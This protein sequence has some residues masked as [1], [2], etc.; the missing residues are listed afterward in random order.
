MFIKSLSSHV[1]L[2]ICHGSESEKNS[3]SF[4]QW[5]EK[6][7]EHFGINWFS[8]LIGN[9]IYIFPIKYKQTHSLSLKYVNNMKLLKGSNK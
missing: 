6:V 8:A 1:K 2:F 9:V 4:I 3:K 5:Q 7:F